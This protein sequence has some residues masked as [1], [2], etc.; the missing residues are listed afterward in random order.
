[1]NTGEL[2]VAHPFFPWLVIILAAWVGFS[3]AAQVRNW[4]RIRRLERH[5]KLL[6][7]MVENFV[8]PE[9]TNPEKR[10]FEE[11]AAVEEWEDS[12]DTV[13]AETNSERT[14][15]QTT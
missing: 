6:Q 2:W 1:M 14:T 9:Q 15:A 12:P 3:T 10:C 5:N 4:V 13:T 11:P 7:E 8:K